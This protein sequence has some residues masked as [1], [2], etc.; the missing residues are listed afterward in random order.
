MNLHPL[1]TEDDPGR[2]GIIDKQGAV[3]ALP[4]RR[5][6]RPIRERHEWSLGYIRHKNLGA[7]VVPRRLEGGEQVVAAPVAM[8]FWR[9]IE[10]VAQCFSDPTT[11]SDGCLEQ[12]AQFSVSNT[13]FTNF[14]I[15]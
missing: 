14:V 15:S 1:L 11:E 5:R 8:H 10:P 3:E 12:K 7:A 2:T 13:A 9:P 6:D 4:I